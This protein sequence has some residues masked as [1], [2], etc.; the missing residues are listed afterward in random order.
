[1][2][3]FLAVVSKNGVSQQPPGSAQAPDQLARDILKELIEIDTS[4][5]TGDC[6][7]AA[8]AMVAR[9]KAAGFPSEDVQVIGP[10]PRKRNLVARY[11]GNG[12]AKPLLM[13][14]HLDVV[15]ARRED[16]SF[17]PFRFLEMDGF[18]YGR[19]TT[20]DKGMAAIWIAT[21]IRLKQE[22]FQPNRDLIVAL[23]ADEEGGSYNGVQWLLNNDRD[24]IDADFALNEGGGGQIKS[25]TRVLNS[26][27]ASEKVYQSYRL[28]VHS[29]GGH[30]ARPT[31]ENTIYELAAGLLRLSKYEFPVRLNEVTEAYFQRMSSLTYGQVADDLRAVT[32]K[33]PDAK[34]I[35]RLSASPYY[36]ALLH[37][38]CVATRLE[39]GHAD[40]ALA[41]TAAAVVNCRIQPGDAPREI[42][43]TLVRIL[44]DPKITVTPLDE[45]SPS[46]PSPLR[47][48]VLIPIEKITSQMWPGIPVVPVMSTGATD[49]IYLRNAGIPTYG[50]SGVFS[51][52]DD[53]RSHGKDERIG[54]KE[55]YEGR[56][57]LYRLIKAYS[58]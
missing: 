21:L 11:R 27:Q 1:M 47:P 33:P 12:T 22:G 35:A 5:S 24:L 38:T 25:G 17:D 36:N 19:G 40:N 50:V 32:R 18:F 42:E 39:G 28:E 49:G 54:I 31:K 3:A 20:D 4:D 53:S 56:E 55:F 9:L 14:A 7:K 45:A 13:L 46:S 16:W 43:A 2:A 57:F 26:V 15:E 29:V 37:T 58:S 8:E 52:V 34:A 6:T 23:T 30:S 41:Q 10:H 48:D 51:D 44:N